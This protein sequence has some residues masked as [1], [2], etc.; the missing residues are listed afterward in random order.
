MLSSLDLG[1][2]GWNT[3]STGP[4]ASKPFFR[5][6]IFVGPVGGVQEPAQIADSGIV[7]A[8][9]SSHPSQITDGEHSPDDQF[10]SQWSRKI[11]SAEQ[12]VLGSRHRA[13]TPF[14]AWSP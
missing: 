6:L 12:D 9:L 7:C 5:A 13:G 8:S 3:F 14:Q 11:S 2:W 10:F 1:E 4:S